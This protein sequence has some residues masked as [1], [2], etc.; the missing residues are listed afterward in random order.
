[1]FIRAKDT[2]IVNNMFVSFLAVTL[3]FASALVLEILCL[4]M[5]VCLYTLNEVVLI[6]SKDSGEFNPFYTGNP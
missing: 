5:V 3:I 2:F 4:L 1:M 6:T